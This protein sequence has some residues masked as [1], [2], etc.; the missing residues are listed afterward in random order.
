[1]TVKQLILKKANEVIKE[2]G[3]ILD[4][5][6]S[7][8]VLSYFSDLDLSVYESDK[9]THIDDLCYDEY[10]CSYY[11]LIIGLLRENFDRYCSSDDADCDTYYY[12]KNDADSIQAV[13]DDNQKCNEYP[14]RLNE[15]YYNSAIVLAYN[16]E[17]NTNDLRHD[18]GC[19]LGSNEVYSMLYDDLLETAIKHWGIAYIQQYAY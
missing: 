9:Y 7:S 5:E 11:D 17:Y 10:G 12:N 4:T 15:W 14:E 19:A 2:E 6:D 16:Y 3:Y 8:N 18:L 13:Y 1:M